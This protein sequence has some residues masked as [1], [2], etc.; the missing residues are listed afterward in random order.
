M[1]TSIIGIL[2]VQIGYWWEE[3]NEIYGHSVL[4]DGYRD[5]IANHWH[6]NCGW[7]GSNNGWYKLDALPPGNGMIYKSCPYA[8]PNNWMY[9]NK[10]HSGTKNG[11]IYYP[12]NTLSEGEASSINNGKL[13]IKTGTYTGTGNVPITFDNAVAIRAYAGDV[14]MGENLWLMN[15]E[16]IRLHGNGQ[17]KITPV[18]SGE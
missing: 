10:D 3:N 1:M 14:V 12:Y 5:D 13:L 15:Y 4:T 2:P 9:I 11:L 16:T 6:I 18:K 7:N 8:Q 17:L